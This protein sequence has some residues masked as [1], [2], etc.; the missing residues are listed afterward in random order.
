MVYRNNE[1]T[2]HGILGQKWGVRRFQP[3]PDGYNGPGK[4]IGEAAKA[5]K[6]ATKYTTNAIGIYRSKDQIKNDI[7]RLGEESYAIITKLYG[8]AGTNRICHYMDKGNNIREAMK[9]EDENRETIAD[10]K[11]LLSCGLSISAAMNLT[12]KLPAIMSTVS[13]KL[14]TPENIQKGQQ[15]LSKIITPEMLKSVITPEMINAS[16]SLTESVI[17]P[18]MLESVTNQMMNDPNLVKSITKNAISEPAQTTIT[19]ETINDIANQMMSDPD[20]VKSI[21][22]NIF[23][24]P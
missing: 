19:S 20:L 12:S 2:H 24:T 7:S 21:T 6:K 4:M 1:L 17:T 8:K 15:L 5:V 11:F 22:K 18:E 3:Y 13:S 16:I 23:A 9:L 10:C 14:L